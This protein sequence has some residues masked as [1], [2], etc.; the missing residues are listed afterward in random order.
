MVALDLEMEEMARSLGP[1]I[2]RHH[3]AGK[4]LVASSGRKPNTTSALSAGISEQELNAISQ[5]ARLVSPS[6]S[7]I[8]S[9]RQRS[10]ELS[11]NLCENS[12]MY[13]PARAICQCKQPDKRLA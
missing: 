12:D 5:F 9:R 11:G 10:T 8:H 13:P 1:R 6:W 4:R 2:T 7:A 3:K